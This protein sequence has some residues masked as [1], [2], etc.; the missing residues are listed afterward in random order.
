MDAYIGEDDLG[1][2]FLESVLLNFRGFD[3]FLLLGAGFA[4]FLTFL[5]LLLLSLLI[6]ILWLVRRHVIFLNGELF[7][8]NLSIEL[9]EHR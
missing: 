4:L 9:E 5:L 1:S 3:S 8:E 6:E 2:D 7:L